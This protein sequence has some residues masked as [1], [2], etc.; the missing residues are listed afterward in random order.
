[1]ITWLARDLQVHSEANC[2]VNKL[3][4]AGKIEPCCQEHQ[5][6]PEADTRKDQSPWQ[7]TDP[8]S[9]PRGENGVLRGLCHWIPP[10]LAFRC[11]FV[12]V[13]D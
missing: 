5:A 10:G 1:M 6:S 11:A 8:C 9:H 12:R 4:A 13:S 2:S 7:I 3:F